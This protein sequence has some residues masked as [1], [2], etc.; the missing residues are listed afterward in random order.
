MCHGQPRPAGTA[1]SPPLAHRRPR[2]LAGHRDRDLGLGASTARRAAGGVRRRAGGRLGLGRLR[3]GRPDRP[4]APPGAR[5]PPRADDLRS[6]EG[7]S[8]PLRPSVR[9]HAAAG[10]G[11]A[12]RHRLD[13]R[14]AGPHGAARAGRAGARPR[15][16]RGDDRAGRAWRGLHL[17]RAAAAG[18]VRAAL[19]DAGHRRGGSCRAR[20]RR[21]R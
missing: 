7:G 4:R 5:H 20:W 18:A 12:G 1:T 21:W 3:R 16:R 13:R 15:H 9:R 11:A 6:D 8:R 14:G 17:R 10:A 19:A 2:C